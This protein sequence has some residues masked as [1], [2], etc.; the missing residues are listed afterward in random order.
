M[1][2]DLV[3]RRL[4]PCKQVWVTQNSVGNKEECGLR[5]VTLKKCENLRREDWMRAIIEGKRNQRAVGSDSVQDI[6]SEPLEEADKPY[7]LC[8][9]D[10]QSKRDGSNPYQ[11]QHFALL[12]QPSVTHFTLM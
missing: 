9:K 4:Y 6:R 11:Y 7:R 1:V 8:P 3:A 5:I 2:G 12:E 10:E